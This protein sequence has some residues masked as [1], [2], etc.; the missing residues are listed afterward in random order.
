MPFVSTRLWLKKRLAQHVR[1]QS[2]QAVIYTSSDVNTTSSSTVT[3]DAVK[4]SF[5]QKII[6]GEKLNSRHYTLKVS[7]IWQTHFWTSF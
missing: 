5:R 2:P 3:T 1:K 4:R 7:V 6:N